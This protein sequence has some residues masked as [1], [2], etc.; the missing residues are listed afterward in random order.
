MALIVIV[1]VVVACAAG[2]GATALATIFLAVLAVLVEELV[3]VAL[4]Y[5]LRTV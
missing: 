4:R 1:L 5:W 3:R 2:H